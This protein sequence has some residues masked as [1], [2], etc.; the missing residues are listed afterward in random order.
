MHVHKNVHNFLFQCPVLLCGSTYKKYSSL[1][2]H[3]SRSHNTELYDSG[4]KANSVQSKRTDNATRTGILNTFCDICQCH[5]IE[6]TTCNSILKHLK[7]HLKLSR[8]PTISCPYIHCKQ[9]YRVLSSF[10]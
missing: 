5:Y 10:C 7:S 3:I 2:S 9:S 4:N 1:H 6:S 8:P